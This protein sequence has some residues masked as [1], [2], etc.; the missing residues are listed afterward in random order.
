MNP[1]RGIVLILLAVTLFSGMSAFIKAAGRIP[2]GEAV[3]FRSACA[4]PIIILWLWM[5][6]DLAQGLRV[7]SYRKHM[8]RSFAGTM[9][10]GLT[11]ASLKYL[12]LP[13]VTALRFVTPILIVLLAALL[14]GEQIRLMRITAVAV[15]LLGVLVILWPRLGA[16]L[17]G[18]GQR[19]M[20][21]AMMV[22]ASAG[23]AAFAQ[24]SL[25]RMAGVEKTAAIVFF[26]SMTSMLIS[27]F[28][29]PFGW[30]WP[31]RYEWL[32]L[33]GAGV[34]GGAGQILLTSSYRFADAGVLAPFTYVSMIWSLLIGYF[35]FGEAPTWAML[36]GALLII[37]SGVAIVLRERQLGK[38]LPVTGKFPES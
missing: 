20:I 22:L 17:A 18:A 14:L 37:L 26:F 3:F 7:Q 25:K 23:F 27:L 4:L 12:P 10:M 9:A 21:G 6:G 16:S 28:S 32:F 31:Q 35:I 38:K 33:I 11:F 19:E 30:V 15:G 5:R 13:E 29:L 2:A 8:Y 36:A 34:I 24:I 1:V